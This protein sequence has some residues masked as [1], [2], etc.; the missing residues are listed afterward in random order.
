[1]V[2]FKVIKLTSSKD[3]YKAFLRT[4]RMWRHT[5]MVKCGGRSYNPAGIDGTSPGELAVL[6]PAYPI[7][8]I[9]LPPNWQSVGEESKYVNVL[10]G[11]PFSLMLLI[12]GTSTTRH[13]AS[14]PAF[15]SRGDKFQTMRKILSWVLGLHT[16][17]H[18][19][20]ILSI[21]ITLLIN[22]R[23]VLFILSSASCQLTIVNR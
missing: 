18:G 14:M 5:R 10:C 11:C 4:L 21:F 9:N 17:S 8:S 3:R 23:F 12:L 1:M 16:S 22:M 15:A 19:V 2:I 6:C 7:P 20:H 13:L